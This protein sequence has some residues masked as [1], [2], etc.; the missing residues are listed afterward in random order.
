[1]CSCGEEGDHI[2]CGCINDSRDTNILI[3]KG[4]N[5]QLQFTDYWITL[6]FK[7]SMYFSAGSTCKPSTWICVFGW[8]IKNKT[9]KYQSNDLILSL[10]STLILH[11]LKSMM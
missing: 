1:M 10:R 8:K 2:F 11:L 4:I 3:N 5:L 6:I 7:Q 9:V